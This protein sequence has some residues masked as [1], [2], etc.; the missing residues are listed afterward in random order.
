MRY[1]ALLRAINVGGR[2][3]KME[4]LRRHF[5][6][7]GLTHVETFINSG[8]V[9][10]ETRAGKIGSLEKKIE[11]Q[12]EEMMGYAVPTFVRTPA[13]MAAIA[14]YDPFPPT[15]PEGGVYVAFVQAPPSAEIKARLAAMDTETDKF[16]AHNCEVHWWRAGR[17]SDSPLSSSGRFEKLLGVPTT[18][19]N[20]TTVR[21]L[22][23]KY[24]A[25]SKSK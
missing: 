7:L 13:E 17:Y 16:H 18:V 11:A 12:L 19:R 15:P 2:T 9:I 6:A 20:I 1:I 21:K 22:A 5:E 24:P 14:A 23:E 3:I 10:F 4:T 25:E 8:N